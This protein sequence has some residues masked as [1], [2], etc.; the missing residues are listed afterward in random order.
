MKETKSLNNNP[1]IMIH[2]LL[3]I[4]ALGMFSI[5]LYLTKHYFDVKFP[6]DLAQTSAC[7]INQFFNCDATTLSFASN[8]LGVPI[9]LFGLLYGAFILLGYL[10]RN[11]EVEGTNHCLSL[12]N[13]AGCLILF[14]YSIVV[15]KSICPFCSIYYVLSFIVAFIYFKHSDE[16]KPSFKVL[17]IY[18][19]L[20]AVPA[21]SLAM[22]SKDKSK[23]QSGLKE[24]LLKQ[25]DSLENLGNPKIDSPY[26]LISGAEKFSDTPIQISIFSDFQCPACRALGEQLHPLLARYKGQLNIQ[27]FFYP[28]DMSC[29]SKMTS[30]MHPFACQA[31]YLASCL[32]QKFLQIHDE[33]FL[34]QENFSTEWLQN[35]ATKNGVLECMSTNQTMDKV[36]SLI[37]VGNQFDVRSTPTMILNGVKIEGVLPTSQLQMLIDEL[38]MRP[39]K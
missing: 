7:N 22:V 32:P 31:A 29:N 24:S 34:N 12:V 20:A 10:F 26:R 16:K 30:A 17:A 2:S 25:Y 3:V 23:E 18:A 19:L 15:L 14:T 5:S 21:A 1:S 8:I 27:Y 33:L 37:E 13:A 11:E 4:C 28:L 39:K 35:L 9:A 36:K 38:I 6:T